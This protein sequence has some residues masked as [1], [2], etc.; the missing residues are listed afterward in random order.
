MN[1]TPEP[2][3]LS[4]KAIGEYA[5][6]VGR[7]HEIYSANG[8]ADIQK[9]L[10]SLGGRV[11]MSPELFDREALTVY[12]P[13]NFEIHIPQ[14][15]SSRRDRFTIAHELGHYFLHYLHP[16]T[17]GMRTFGRGQRNWA[18]TQANV[19]ASHLLMPEEA[20]RTAY[21]EHA[22]DWWS[23]AQVFNVSPSAAQVRAQVLGLR[24]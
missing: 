11:T 1:G 22:G 12:E 20:F 8:H 13:G 4:N 2:S 16:K 10:A 7:H 14:F 15:T 17:T 23:I 3:P 19:F 24:S 6:L 9:L 21:R 18:E 5:D